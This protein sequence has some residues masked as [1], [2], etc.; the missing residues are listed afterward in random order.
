MLY[1]SKKCTFNKINLW[2]KAISKK[3]QLVNWK[4]KLI[5]YLK[6]NWKYALTLIWKENQENEQMKEEFLKI[7]DFKFD[8]LKSNELQTLIKGREMN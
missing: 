8:Y 1:F 2:P 3:N 6:H 4:D 5:L 7:P